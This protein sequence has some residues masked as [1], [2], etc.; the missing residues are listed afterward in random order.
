ML[1]L[2]DAAMLI[3]NDAQQ[4]CHAT[5]SALQVSDLARTPKANSS[6]SKLT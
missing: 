2:D 6:R 4:T 1:K 5:L 3:F